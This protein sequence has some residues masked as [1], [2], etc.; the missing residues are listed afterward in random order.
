MKVVSKLCLVL[1]LSGC[2]GQF[3]GTRGLRESSVTRRDSN[4][5][6]LEAEG[7]LPAAALEGDLLMRQH[8]TIVWGDHTES[9]DAVLQ[10]RGGE[11]V[12]LGLG[13][14]NAVGFSLTLNEGIVR[15]EN[16]TGRE[17]LFEPER[18]MTDVQRVFYPWIEEAW[19]CTVC[20]RRGFRAGVEISERIGTTNLEERRFRSIARPERGEIVVRYSE[21]LEDPP[22]PKHAVLRDGRFDYELI[23]ETISVERLD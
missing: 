16:R 18:I 19:T 4:E 22:V 21:W 7:L 15:F 14:M 17:M 3:S 9:F 23:V 1:L 5:N 2:A 13:V 6:H 11:L 12:L 8:V 10:K 20:E